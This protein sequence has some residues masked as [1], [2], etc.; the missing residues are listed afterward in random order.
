MWL[1]TLEIRKKCLYQRKCLNGIW[2]GVELCT[3]IRRYKASRKPGLIYSSATLVL[4]ARWATRYR[5]YWVL[6]TSV[7]TCSPTVCFLSICCCELWWFFAYN[8]VIVLKS[9]FLPD[10]SEVGDCKKQSLVWSVSK[11]ALLTSPSFHLWRW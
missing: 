8:F 1:L 7:I 3:W 6:I 4:F 9:P 11:S 10:S 2:G 5:E